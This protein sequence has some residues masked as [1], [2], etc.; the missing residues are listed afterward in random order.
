[1]V[2]DITVFSVTF[3]QNQSDAESI[4]VIW[5][6]CVLFCFVVVFCFFVFNGNLCLQGN[7]KMKETDEK[8]AHTHQQ[9]KTP[10]LSVYF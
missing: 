2:L 4:A 5:L 7:E 1:M 8:L 6:V 3:V 10:K 9:K